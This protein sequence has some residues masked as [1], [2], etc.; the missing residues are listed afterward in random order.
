MYPIRHQQQALASRGREREGSELT[1]S[2]IQ[3]AALACQRVLSELGTYLDVVDWISDPNLRDTLLLRAQ[4]DVKRVTKLMSHIV[5]WTESQRSP[6]PPV[7][8]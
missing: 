2:G 3:E 4:K 6:P 7:A 1:L 5:I 8:T